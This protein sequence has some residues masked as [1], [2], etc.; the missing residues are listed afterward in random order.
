MIRRMRTPDPSV[1]GRTA[2]VAGAT[3]L[4]GR[5]I[6]QELL[7][8]DAV[9]AVHALVR[10]PLGLRHP[11]LTQHTVDFARLPPL[12]AALMVVPSAR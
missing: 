7:D 11:R 1:A 12:P 10:R 2:L 8:D 4:V 9:A 5:Q 3:G 6:L